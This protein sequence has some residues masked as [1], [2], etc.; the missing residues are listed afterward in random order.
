MN[1]VIRAL[2]KE[3]DV[4]SKQIKRLRFHLMEDNPY[5]D[6]IQ[7]HIELAELCEMYPNKGE[8]IEFAQGLKSLSAREK[9]VRKRIAISHRLHQGDGMER[10]CKAEIEVSSLLSQ[11]QLHQMRMKSYR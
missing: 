9:A 5:S 8:S 2:T 3:V 6:L 1:A 7:I 10:L 11:I 4:L